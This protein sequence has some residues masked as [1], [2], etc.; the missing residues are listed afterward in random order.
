MTPEEIK[1]IT[2]KA[3]DDMNS[4]WL[5]AYARLKARMEA[6]HGDGTA[7]REAVDAALKRL[8]IK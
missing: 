1:R 4:D 5:L 3:M 7:R 6:I 8:G 2:E